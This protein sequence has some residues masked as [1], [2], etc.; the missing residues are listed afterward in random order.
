MQE[1]DGHDLRDVVVV[2]R[3]EMGHLLDVVT[4]CLS[5]SDKDDVIPI[6]VNKKMRKRTFSGKD[7]LVFC[8]DTQEKWV[9]EFQKCRDGVWER[10]CNCAFLNQ[11]LRE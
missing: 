3:R 8:L 10:Q 2:E 5:L 9:I 7:C 6:N 1:S 4:R 11:N